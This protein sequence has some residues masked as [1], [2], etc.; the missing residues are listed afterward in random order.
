MSG[1]PDARHHVSLGERD[2]D[3]A[4]TA[5]PTSTLPAAHRRPGV[6]ALASRFDATAQARALQ[7]L[8]AS[9]ARLR[10]AVA[11]D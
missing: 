1:S 8:H 5:V 6:S 2:P 11:Q 9:A 7:A 10:Q 3:I 4:A